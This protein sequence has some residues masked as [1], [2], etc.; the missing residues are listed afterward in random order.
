MLISEL[1]KTLKLHKM[2]LNSEDGGVHANLR[3][4]NLID[5]N[6][7]YANLIDANLRYA[8]L[9]DANLRDAN[10]RYADLS[11]ANLSNADL[12]Y[13]DLRGADLRGAKY[14]H[15]GITAKRFTVILNLYKYTVIPIISKDGDH[16][17]ALGCKFQ[18]R[19]DWETNFW[20]NTSE[21]PNDGGETTESRKFALAT[22]CAWLDMAQK[23]I[24]KENA[25]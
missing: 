14:S 15:K 6:L 23:Q 22:A 13:A 4:A 24:D 3:D 20:N 21:F 16:W 19:K 2:W 9:I 17:I 8:N 18:T 1:E 10:L 25:K 12:S 7:R 11:Y 5:A